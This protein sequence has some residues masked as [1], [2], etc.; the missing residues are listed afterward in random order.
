M[1]FLKIIKAFLKSDLAWT[2]GAAF[3]FGMA[4]VIAFNSI[5]MSL[6]LDIPWAGWVYVENILQI[7]YTFEL[8]LRLKKQCCDFFLDFDN[9]VW[10]YL[11]FIMVGGGA[12]DLWLVPLVFTLKGMFF[13]S[14]GSDSKDDSSLSGAKHFLNS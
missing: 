5:I 11:D 1:R 3:E 13:G 9:M 6:E 4:G 12:L 10:N 8:A 2:E 14:S 7:V